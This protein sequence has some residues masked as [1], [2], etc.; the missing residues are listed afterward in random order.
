MTPIFPKASPIAYYFTAITIISIL[1]I[2]FTKVNES[3]FLPRHYSNN[4]FNEHQGKTLYCDADNKRI[5]T[6]EEAFEEL[7]R[8]IKIMK[9]GGTQN[10]KVKNY[11][12]GYGR[13]ELCELPIM[14]NC[15]FLSFGIEWD[16]SFDLELAT[17]KVKTKHTLA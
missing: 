8:M 5:I 16:Y 1:A 9:F 10:C 17:G 4:Y 13:H 6:D 12:T 2:L 15:R 14:S 7:R 11:G 3:Y